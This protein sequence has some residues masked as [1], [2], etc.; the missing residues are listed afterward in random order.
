VA[1]KSSAVSGTSI[2]NSPFIF[3]PRKLEDFAQNGSRNFL[4]FLTP[5]TYAG[6]LIRRYP[7]KG[8]STRSPDGMVPAG[9]ALIA[10]DT[11]AGA[12]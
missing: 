10:P 6:V 2:R 9:S 11:S 3:G 7:G 1:R 4:V 5:D 8:L 12:S